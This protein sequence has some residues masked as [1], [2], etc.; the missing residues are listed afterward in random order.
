MCLVY[1]SIDPTFSF[2]NKLRGGE[3]GGDASICSSIENLKYG[4]IL[5]KINSKQIFSQTADF[6]L[7]LRLH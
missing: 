6:L 1:R 7:I 2:T 4:K 3:E 5:I